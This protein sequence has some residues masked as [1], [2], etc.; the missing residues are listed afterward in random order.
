[1][2]FCKKLHSLTVK[3]TII[4]YKFLLLLDRVFPEFFVTNFNSQSLKG[5]ET[6]L[7]RFLIYTLEMLVRALWRQSK[8]LTHCGGSLGLFWSRVP[9]H[10][11]CCWEPLWKQNAYILQ[12]LW[13]R[14]KARYLHITIAVGG[15]FQSKVLIHCS[16]CGAPLKAR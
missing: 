3:K 8:L 1:M 13:V 14:L 10:C 12:L 15:P 4:W 7:K 2:V 9:T 6:G 16:C 5:T 11:S